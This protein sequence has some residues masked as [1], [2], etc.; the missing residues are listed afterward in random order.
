MPR[1]KPNIYRC[2]LSGLLI[3][4]ALAGCSLQSQGDILRIGTFAA[5]PHVF[6][7]RD[8]RPSGAGVEYFRMVLQRMGMEDFVFRDYPISRLLHS[9]EHG[10]VDIALF[11]ARTP[12]RARKFQYPKTSLYAAQAGIAV[13]D[14]SPLSRIE[15]IADLA[16]FRI[17]VWQDAYVSPILAHH[18]LIQSPITG[19]NSV[20]RNLRRLLTNRI[21]ATYN[22]DIEVLRFKV[23]QLGLE[24]QIRLL[25]L[26]EPPTQAYPVFSKAV[27]AALI[28]RYELAIRSGQ[29]PDYRSFL[30]RYTR[31]ATHAPQAATKPS[32]YPCQRGSTC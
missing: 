21:D 13:R 12:E 24:D 32:R 20:E 1:H 31:E 14:E 22:P 15:S 19:G 27:A 2:R 23:H 18:G 4:L 30:D 6:V 10:E 26:P 16:G 11:L 25:P 8:Q 3:V 5:E 7:G 28:P 29:L 17:G 9:L